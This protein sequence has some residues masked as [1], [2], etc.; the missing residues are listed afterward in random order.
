[1]AL[2]WSGPIHATITTCAPDKGVERISV[3]Q[4]E[5]PILRN[6]FALLARL[7]ERMASHHEAKDV[8]EVQVRGV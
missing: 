3:C 4:R 2:A 8:F 1:V 7:P 6:I 5:L